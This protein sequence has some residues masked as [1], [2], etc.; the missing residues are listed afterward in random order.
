MI[1]IRRLLVLALVSAAPALAATRQ[2]WVVNGSGKSVTVVDTVQAS[3]VGTIPLTQGPVAE[4]RAIAFSTADGHQGAFAFVGQGH[5]LHVLDAATRSLTTTFDLSNELQRTVEDVADLAASPSRVLRDPAPTV[6]SYLLVAADV[7]A[8]VGSRSEPY[9][10]VLDQR[11][12]IGVAPPQTP[13]VVASGP[14]IAQTVPPSERGEATGVAV[15]GAPFGAAHLRAWFTT[16]GGPALDLQRVVLL[17]K[18]TQL[19]SPWTVERTVEHPLASALPA[20]EAARVA[21]PHDR[22]M[23]ILPTGADGTLVNLDSQGSCAPGGELRQVAIAGPGVGGYQLVAIDGTADT[24]VRIN[25]ASCAGESFAVGEDPVALA[26]DATGEQGEVVVASRDSDDLTILRRDDSL[27][28]VP[29]GQG[30]PGP[31][32]LCPAGVASRRCCAGCTVGELTVTTDGTDDTL[33]W[34]AVGCGGC[35]VAVF[36]QCEIANDTSCPCYCDPDA[37]AGVGDPCYANLPPDAGF[38]ALGETV[39]GEGPDTETP[40]IQLGVSF[41]SGSFVHFGAGPNTLNY[42]VVGIEP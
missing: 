10:L 4:P 12:L 20:P 41:S 32:Q 31:C 13:L 9:F 3:V 39:Y 30:G 38:L 19:G 21:V 42:A 18:D 40:W 15:P 25:G 22:E 14:L 24:L 5:R 17:G 1:G 36:C 35:Q 28:T 6:V 16:R 29:L 2:A 23:A 7:A 34:T 8:G 27:V 26:I 37:P 33:D 11:V